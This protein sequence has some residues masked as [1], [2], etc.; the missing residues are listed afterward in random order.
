MILKIDEIGVG[1]EFYQFFVGVG[2]GEAEG[3]QQ[4]VY[5][6]FVEQF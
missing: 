1:N 5:E 6:V 2:H 3:Y 4:G